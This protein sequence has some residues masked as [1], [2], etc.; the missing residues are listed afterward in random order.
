MDVDFFLRVRVGFIRQLYETSAAAYRERKRLIEAGQ[1]PYEPPYSEDGE[2]PFLVE[3]EE[4]DDSLHV[5]GYA[6]LSMLSD[7]MK[8]FLSTWQREARVRDDPS[9]QKIFQKRGFVEGYRALFEKS[10]GIRFADSE[11][12]LRLLEQVVMAR[13]RIQHQEYLGSNRPSHSQSDLKRFHHP[14]FVDKHEHSVL[15]REKKGESIWLMAPRVSV[16]GE[17]LLSVLKE[18]ERFSTWMDTAMQKVSERRARRLHEN[19]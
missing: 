16:T 17:Q 9:L 3:W 11:V 14:F 8:V 5:L 12:D 18:V 10:L 6:C 7:T 4:A 1:A 19:P 2:P 15:V 13:N